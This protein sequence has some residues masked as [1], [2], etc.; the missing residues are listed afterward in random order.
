MLQGGTTNGIRFK[1]ETAQVELNKEKVHVSP[2]YFI[3]LWV[4][5]F[6][7]TIKREAEIEL[8]KSMEHGTNEGSVNWKNM[9]E[10]FDLPHVLRG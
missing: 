2:V 1:N 9:G 3:S 7:N 8:K 10:N 6:D 5:R 4:K